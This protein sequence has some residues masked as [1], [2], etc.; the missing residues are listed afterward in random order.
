MNKIDFSESLNHLSD[1]II[2]EADRARE[3]VTKRN[4]RRVKYIAAAACAALVIGTGVFFSRRTH[5]EVSPNRE[6][7]S[8]RRLYRR[9]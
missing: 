4:N 7:E 1:G 5:I 2:E 9:H 8:L 3:S 6:D